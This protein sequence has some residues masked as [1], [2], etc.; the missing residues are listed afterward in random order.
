MDFV[1][2]Q[3]PQIRE[4]LADLGLKTLDPLLSAI[5]KSILESPP[6]EDDGISEYEG[7][8]LMEHIASKNSYH[9]FDTYLGAGAYEHHVPAL[10]RAIISKSEFLTAYTPYQAE[11]SQGTLQTI[12]EF[13]SVLCRLTGLDVANASLYD[14]ASAAGEALLMSLRLKPNRNKVLVAGNLHPHYLRVV[15][16]YVKSLDIE[17]V[18]IPFKANGDLN[19][20]NFEKELDENTA[21]VLFAYPNF[22]GGVENLA[23]WIEKVHEKEA[24]ALLCA[25]PLIFGL[26]QSAKDLKADIVIGDTQ[27]FGIPLQFG[28]PYA[29]YMTCRREFIRQIPGRLVGKTNDLDGQEGFVLTLQ[30]REQHIRREKATSSICSN[31]ALCALASLVAIL[32]YG[33][34]GV[35][36]LALTNYQR[37]EYLRQELNKLSG[38]DLLSTTPILNEFTIKSAKPLDEVL[39]HFRLR[40]IEPGIPM[41]LFYPEMEDHL[42]ITVTETKSLD[43]LKYYLEVAKE[44]W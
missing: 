9:K 1:S 21:A 18:K 23:P 41:R 19:F 22:L 13:Q 32:W 14:G 44:I 37:A 6:I 20:N 8:K 2:N 42:L 36:N 3:E 30:T 24:L 5:P 16:Q 35:P 4:M 17:Y 34:E 39:N 40:N 25:N 27:P 38:V 33:S 15:Y 28:G 29:G 31:Q 7:L 43:Q 11:A 10:V 26:Y 12:F